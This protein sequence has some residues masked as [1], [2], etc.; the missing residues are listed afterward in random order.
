[1]NGG[2]PGDLARAAYDDGSSP[3]LKSVSTLRP[4]GSITISFPGGGGYGPPGQRDPAAI[5]TDLR[6]GYA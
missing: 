2:S 6:E 3:G 5:E 4:G 1:M